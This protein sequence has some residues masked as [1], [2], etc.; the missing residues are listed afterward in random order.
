MQ[1]Q[2]IA[3]SN[4]QGVAF[5]QASASVSSVNQCLRVSQPSKPSHPGAAFD[6]SSLLISNLHDPS[7]RQAFKNGENF[8]IFVSFSSR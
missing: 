4:G 3:V 8:G 5:A 6:Y 1:A 7:Y 2:A